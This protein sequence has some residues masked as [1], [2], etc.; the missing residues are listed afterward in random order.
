MK[1]CKQGN[2]RISFTIRANFHRSGQLEE[3]RL[4]TKKP[5]SI[6]LIVQYQL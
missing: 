2:D 3:D 1:E 4:E 6:T 5:M